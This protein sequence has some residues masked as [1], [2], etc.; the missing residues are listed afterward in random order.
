MT[1]TLGLAVGPGGVSSAVRRGDGQPHVVGSFPTAE[2]AVTAGLLTVS[3]ESPARVVL[4]HP[5]G[6][7]AAELERHVGELA[8]VGLAGEDIELRSD[9]EVLTAVTGGRVLLVDADRGMIVGHPGKTAAFDTARLAELV[10]DDAAGTTVAIT[11]HPELREKYRA[12]IRDHE[13]MSVERPALA[14]MALAHPTTSALVSTPR[15]AAALQH[16]NRR[17]RRYFFVAVAGSVILL[18]LLVAVWF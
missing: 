4:V 18:L 8:Q 9:A 5:A 1:W 10:A 13:S 14:A 2:R 16:G 7:A 3:E 12:A 15:T 11:G 6:I 17:L